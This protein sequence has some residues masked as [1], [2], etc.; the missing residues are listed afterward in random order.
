MLPQLMATR[1]PMRCPDGR[2]QTRLH[3]ARAKRK[4]LTVPQG[5]QP[6]LKRG[7]WCGAIS[8]SPPAS[9]AKRSLCKVCP[10]PRNSHGDVM[11]GSRVYRGCLPPQLQKRRDRGIARQLA[12]LELSEHSRSSAIG[13]CPLLAA[14]LLEAQ[15]SHRSNCPGA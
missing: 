7:G 1:H 11:N 14:G 13:P 9:S 15:V 3:L 8:S 4:T 12:S 5:R 10:S 6:T 2:A